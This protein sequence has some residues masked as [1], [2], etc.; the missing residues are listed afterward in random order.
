MAKHSSNKA[1]RG[2]SQMANFAINSFADEAAQS[3]H[4]ADKK[5]TAVKGAFDLRQ[6]KGP[7]DVVGDLHGCTAE[8]DELLVKLGYER[9][10]AG[11]LGHSEARTL[12]FLGDLGDR[13]PHSAQAFQQV[14]DW[15]EAGDALYTPGNHCNKLMRYLQG[16][17]VQLTQGL[18]GTVA[19]VAMKEEMTPGFI[20]RLRAF[21]EDAP[22]YLWLDEGR[23]V[24]AHGGIKAHLIG[25]DGS[26]VRRMCLY[27]DITGEKNSDGTPVRLDWAQ[28]YRGDAAIVYGHT[29]VSGPEWVNHTINVDQG[30]VFGG[31]LTAL[32][33][34][35][36][37]VVQVRS[38]E[39]YYT[40]RTPEFIRE[41][42]EGAKE[43]ESSN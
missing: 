2:I 38:H 14:M 32:R 35:E 21:I 37:E 24:V 11:K 30:C 10:A 34:P 33:W 13:G 7:F 20:G 9:R 4:R 43:D 1:L 18:E 25:R 36:R 12:I 31:W 15:V 19:Q 40:E 42:P 39:K 3:D 8:L 26:D 5:L 22:P 6:R 17:H 28:H 16:R 23:L 27:G 29:P 41:A